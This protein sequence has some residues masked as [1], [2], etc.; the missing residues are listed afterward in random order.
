MRPGY[1]QTA[2]LREW[3]QTFEHSE[4]P[5]DRK[6]KKTIRDASGEVK[7][8]SEREARGSHSAKGQQDLELFCIAEKKMFGIPLSPSISTLKKIF[9]KP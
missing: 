4:R 9:K 5:Q 2:S 8:K 6:I 3:L 7:L 1:I